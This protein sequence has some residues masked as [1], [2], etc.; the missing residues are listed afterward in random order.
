MTVRCYRSVRPLVRDAEVFSKVGRPFQSVF[1]LAGVTNI[2][3][4]IWGMIKD[5]GRIRFYVAYQ[6]E[7]PV[8]V[9]PL[10]LKAG[11][12][13]VIGSGRERMDYVDFL[14]KQ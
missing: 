4:R 13:R 3:N 2:V 7:T 1:V 6:D 10:Y 5:F 9:V 11:V 8:L 12:G 14:E